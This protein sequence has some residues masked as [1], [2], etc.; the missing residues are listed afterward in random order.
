M[1][2]LEV[3]DVEDAGVATT[4]G[5]LNL[6]DADGAVEMG[7]AA[8]PRA[9]A[10]VPLLCSS[11]FIALSTAEDAT[12]WVTEGALVVPTS[13]SKRMDRTGDELERI[14]MFV[15]INAAASSGMWL[16]L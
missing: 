1:H 12:E 9:G 6:T 13:S 4:T 11:G 5:G 15:C 7:V 14:D 3:V 16:L 10:G 2:L 8:D